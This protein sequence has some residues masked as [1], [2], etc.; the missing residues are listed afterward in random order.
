MPYQLQ[1]YISGLSSLLFPVICKGCGESLSTPRTI[2]CRACE[3]ELPRTCFE[4]MTTNPV[5]QMFWGRA[6]LEFATALFYYRK[7]ELLQS[8]IYHLKYKRGKETGIYLGAITA[9]LLNQSTILTSADGILP[10]PLH[11]RKQKIRGYNQAILISEG[12]QSVTG[13]PVHGDA[14]TRTAHSDSQTRRGRYERWENVEGIFKVLSPE[15]LENKHI[16]ILDDV[17]TTG[18]TIEALCGA[19]STVPGIKLSVLTIGYSAS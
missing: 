12:I 8:L 7:A 9:K 18:A 14:A 5:M 10:V 6:R 13:L 1:K 19:L 2:L 17:V 16:L 11:P 15:L 3:S 4:D